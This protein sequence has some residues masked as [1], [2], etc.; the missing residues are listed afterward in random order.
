MNR[1]IANTNDCI[2][3][4]MCEKTCAEFYFGT[5]DK[6]K[7]SITIITEET[8]NRI[9]ICTQCGE[10]IDICPVEAI[11][12]DERGVVVIDKDICVGCLMCVGFCKE[13]AMYYSEDMVYPFKCIA[14]GK[15]VEVC[16]VNALEIER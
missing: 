4:H 5:K 6:K 11:S 16:P 15:C 13:N 9:A 1:I 7:S 3:C 14:C 2:G 8:E 12:R 10:C